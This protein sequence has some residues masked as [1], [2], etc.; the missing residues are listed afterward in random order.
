M[1]GVLKRPPASWP[2]RNATACLACPPPATVV[3]PGHSAI[4]SSPWVAT[5]NYHAGSGHLAALWS[6][7]FNKNSR[8]QFAS[9]SGGCRHR[10]QSSALGAAWREVLWWRAPTDRRR[11]WISPITNWALH[12]LV[13][14]PAGRGS[15]R[16]TCSARCRPAPTPRAWCLDRTPLRHD[17]INAR[18]QHRK[19]DQTSALRDYVPTA[20]DLMA[21]RTSAPA[22][23]RLPLRRRRTSRPPVVI[24][25]RDLRSLHPGLV[26]RIVIRYLQRPRRHQS[27]TCPHRRRRLCCT[28][29]PYRRCQWRALQNCCSCAFQAVALSCREYPILVLEWP[30]LLLWRPSRDK[31]PALIRT[32]T[33]TMMMTTTVILILNGLVKTIKIWLESGAWKRTLASARE[34]IQ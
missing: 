20:L 4:R 26:L 28:P 3:A 31:R 13:Q 29:C 5:D 12:I 10:G 30:Y 34:C 32:R 11:P 25:H 16:A 23:P 33:R 1:P 17:E 6:P 24:A 19:D 9:Q 14:S 15:Q 7:N 8:L 27:Q 21:S 2:P 22:S 18:W